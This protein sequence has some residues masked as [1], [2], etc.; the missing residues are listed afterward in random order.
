MS[1]IRYRLNCSKTCSSFEGNPFVS[2]T[3]WAR[4]QALAGRIKQSFPFP[5]P[6]GM[7]SDVYTLPKSDAPAVRPIRVLLA[8]DHAV[9]L[10]GLR[11][12]VENA[13]PPMIVSGTA[14]TR[15]ELLA[16]PALAQADVV[17]LD[18][19]FR[20][21]CALDC[22]PQL[23]S[24]AGVKVIVLTGELNPGR[25]R[26]AVMRGARGVVLKSRPTE[27]ILQAIERVHATDAEGAARG[28]A[29]SMMQR[30]VHR[31]WRKQCL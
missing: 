18:L 10:W 4:R 15:R 19:A 7:S 22:V 27:H 24:D 5:V 14:A 2:A 25:H 12:L 28:G 6:I 8:D 13:R 11:Q 29:N 9:T 23:V 1:S 30:Q 3:N 31:Y 16:H 17:V 21:G 20:D 26:E